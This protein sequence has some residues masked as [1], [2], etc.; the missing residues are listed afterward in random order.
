MDQQYL[1]TRSVIKI[2]IPARTVVK[3]VV[4][5]TIAAYFAR[6]LVQVIDLNLSHVNEKLKTQTE[7]Q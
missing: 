5:G 7:K 1:Y 2:Q 6:S 4:V 3:V